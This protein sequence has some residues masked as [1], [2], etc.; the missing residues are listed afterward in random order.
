MARG[1]AA[2]GSTCHRSTLTPIQDPNGSSTI[3][4]SLDAPTG[5]AAPHRCAS[6][7]YSADANWPRVTW[8]RLRVAACPGRDP[9]PIYGITYRVRIAYRAAHRTL[10][11][12][13]G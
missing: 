12:G 4:R 5:M 6:A 10:S 1:T 3:L 7:K 9:E 2:T 11:C 13:D 8:P